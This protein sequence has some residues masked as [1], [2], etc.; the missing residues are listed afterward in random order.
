MIALKEK[1]R[2]KKAGKLQRRRKNATKTATKV[3]KATKNTKLSDKLKTTT[4]AFAE[5][6][7]KHVLRTQVQGDTTDITSGQEEAT[8]TLHREGLSCAVEVPSTRGSREGEVLL[9]KKPP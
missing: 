6:R 8:P 2:L 4:R 5:K 9:R 7:K 1:L 3:T